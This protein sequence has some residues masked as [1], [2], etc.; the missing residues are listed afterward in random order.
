MADL[1]KHFKATSAFAQKHLDK[2]AE[3][4]KAYYDQKA[5]YD[6]LQVGDEVWYYVFA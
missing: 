6:E 3:G 4:R 2:S 1:N 5:S